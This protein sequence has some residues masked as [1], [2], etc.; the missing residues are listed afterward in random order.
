MMNENTVQVREEKVLLTFLQRTS[1]GQYAQIERSSIPYA[2]LEAQTEV[3][4]QMEEDYY[5]NYS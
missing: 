5:Y 4:P 2:R 3:V 1:E